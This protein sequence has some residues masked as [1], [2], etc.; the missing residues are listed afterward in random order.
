LQNDLTDL[1]EGVFEET[2]RP[3]LALHQGDLSI[4]GFEDGVLRVRLSGGCSGCPG[5][6][7]V[8]QGWIEQEVRAAISEVEE[9]IVVNGVSD[10]LLGQARALM[11]LR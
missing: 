10:S 3:L 6:Q 9:V 11:G 8:T 1:I 2:V 7:L 4:A 5:A